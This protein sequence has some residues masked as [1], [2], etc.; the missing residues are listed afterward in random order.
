MVE[1]INGVKNIKQLNIGKGLKST[2]IVN[3]GSGLQSTPVVNKKGAIDL[4]N[5]ITFSTDENKDIFMIKV[6]DTITVKV[7]IFLRD[8]SDYFRQLDFPHEFGEYN[9]SLQVVDQIYHNAADMGIITQTIK[10]AY[11]YTD[12]CYLDEKN[13][14]EYIK[15]INKFNKTIP[16]FDNNVKVDNNKILGNKFTMH[17]NNVINRKNMYLMFIKDDAVVKIP[18]KSCSNIQLKVDSQKFQNPI[19]NNFDAYIIFKNRS[20][21]NEFLL[22]YN[23]FVD[24]YLIYSF[25]LD[26]VLE[27][28][29]GS[30]S[31]DI[32]CDPDDNSES[33]AIIIYQQSAYINLKIENGSLL[34]NKTY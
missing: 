29:S 22:N 26:R 7:P 23:Q 31:V 20:P 32:S 13:K 4:H 25:P 16:I 18:N 8:I 2:P 24:N 15:N 11:L 27:Y 17:L 33:T 21:Y 34:V 30:K 9:I 12:V 14:I 1:V 3:K 10:S 19:D 6:N 5:D 28:D